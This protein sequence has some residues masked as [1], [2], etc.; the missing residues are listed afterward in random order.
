MGV[1]EVFITCITS[2]ATFAT[3]EVP[4]NVVVSVVGHSDSQCA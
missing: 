3:S 2:P 1:N 4:L